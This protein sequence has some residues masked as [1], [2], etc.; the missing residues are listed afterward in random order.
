MVYRL[1]FTA[2]EPFRLLPREATELEEVV[3]STCVS[4]G[5]ARRARA[6]LL[7]GGSSLR[8]VQAQ[9][10]MSP[11][12][13]RHGTQCWRKKGL[14]GLLDAP[15]A[16][17]PRKVTPA[18]ET[19]IVAATQ[20]S[21]PGPL[22][23]WSTRRLGRRW[24]VSRVTVKRLW[25]KVGLQPHRLK[26]YMASPDPDFEAKA[27]DILGL[28][29]EPPEKAAAF[30]IDERTAIQA[31]DRIQP[32]L[33]LRPRHVERHTVE[34][35]R[36]GTVSLFAALEVYSGKVRGRC[37]PRHTS[38]AFVDFLDEALAPHRRKTVH[39]ILDN[40][41]VHK[42]PA[43]KAWAEAHPNV[44]FHFTPTYASW[45]NQVE[46]WLGLITRDC[47]RR[48][49]FRSVP[50]LTHQIR[51]YIRF[52]N[53]NARPFR[54]TYSNPK[55]RIRVSFSSVTRH[56]SGDTLIGAIERNCQPSRRVRFH[57]QDQVKRPRAR[58]ER[59]DPVTG[60]VASLSL[61]KQGSGRRRYHY[62]TE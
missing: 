3:Q 9:T 43:V 61:P 49:I 6:L 8:Q 16:G 29:L 36:H 15:R 48:G 31:L 44:H 56:S 2:K 14:D 25:H 13:T 54:W 47:I 58:I 23:H 62:K 12:R 32:A 45:L 28:Y 24:G 52:Y 50:D 41:S 18:K 7:A 37:A 59:A 30:C 33:P 17:R 27:K 51:K 20:A 42:T 46:N 34:Y 5:L 38:Q 1:M 55:K 19:A 26:R 4:A 39:A 11:R 40:L 22:T 53:R 60:D 57:V 10:G 35:V 21:P